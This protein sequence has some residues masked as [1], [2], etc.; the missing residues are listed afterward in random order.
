MSENGDSILQGLQ[1]PLPD[2]RYLDARPKTDI[3]LTHDVLW[4]NFKP[5]EDA[6]E[7][8]GS[9][10]M[11]SDCIRSNIGYRGDQYDPQQRW[12]SVRSFRSNAGDSLYSSGCIVL[13]S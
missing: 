1:A 5:L 13:R 4:R 7:I 2:K 12:H 11:A 6:R 10:F 9:R 3:I 8:R